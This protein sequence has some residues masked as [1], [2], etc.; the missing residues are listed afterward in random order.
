M[1]RKIGLTSTWTFTIHDSTGAL[2]NADALPVAAVYEDDTDASVDTP[3]V[4]QI[5]VLTGHYRVITY[6]D[7]LI[8]TADH[9]YNVMVTMT[10]GGV[11]MG[12]RVESFVAETANQTD[13]L[14]RLN[15]LISTPHGLI[16]VETEWVVGDLPVG[17]TVTIN[18]YNTTGA[19]EL[20]TDDTCAEFIDGF[21]R[22]N[23]SNMTTYPAVVGLYYWVMK[24]DHDLYVAS[25]MAAIGTP[26]DVAA[27]VEDAVWDAARADHTDAGS[28]GET[29]TDAQAVVESLD[30][31]IEDDGLGQKRFTEKALEEGPGTDPADIFAYVPTGLEPAN[32]IAERI[33][34]I[35]DNVGAPVALD[36]GDATLAGMLTKIADD[37]A[38]ADFNAATD[39]LHEIA[40]TAGGGPTKEEI[41]EEMDDKSTMLKAIR[42][43]VEEPEENYP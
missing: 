43:A 23:T 35:D 31:M 32:S 29:M 25:G 10:V 42:E 5:G 26:T 2:S 17:L 3:T 34:D 18:L 14:D 4:E 9:S 20:L 27:V 21:Y 22:W 19:A 41:R 13:I 37:N 12:A 6:L 36:G 24:D 28:T 16:S 38:G 30:E 39:S 11:S 8:Y 15:S 33:V 7:P 1:T 40:V